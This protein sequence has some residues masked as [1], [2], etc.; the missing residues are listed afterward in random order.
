MK[1][2]LG[3]K[4]GTTDLHISLSQLK[5]LSKKDLKN[6]DGVRFVVHKHKTLAVL[7][8]SDRYH[9]TQRFMRDWQ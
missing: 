2:N 4:K 7:F 1:K 8:S 6:L 5:N 9:E 3:H